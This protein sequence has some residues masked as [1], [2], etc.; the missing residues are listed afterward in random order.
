[1]ATPQPIKG[2]IFK[3]KATSGGSY[4]VITKCMAKKLPS[5][6]A[7]TE[8][9]TAIDSA[10]VTESNQINDYGDL[11]LEILFDRADVVHAAMEAAVGS[12]TDAFIEVTHPDGYVAVYSGNVK[13]FGDKNGG[14]KNNQK[15]DFKMHCNTVPS[16]TA[17]S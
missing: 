7:V 8:E 9:T 1:M 4:A 15:A 3:F 14:P 17:P 16:V 6:T 11:E 13:Q 5:P 12:R 10:C 2:T